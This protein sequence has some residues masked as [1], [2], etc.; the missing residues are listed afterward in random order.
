LTGCNDG[1]DVVT[2]P[3]LPGCISQGRTIKEAKE[4]VKKAISLYLEPEEEIIPGKGKRNAVSA[5]HYVLHSIGVRCKKN[6]W[7]IKTDPFLFH[8]LKPI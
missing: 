2:V 5:F 1:W 8:R 6:L 4:N 3:P 7:N